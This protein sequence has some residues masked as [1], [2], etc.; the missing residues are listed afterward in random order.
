MIWNKISQMLFEAI[1][2]DE[3]RFGGAQQQHQQKHSKRD[4]IDYLLLRER[5]EKTW[6]RLTPK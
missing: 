4:A 3:N 5:E 6:V 2:D 1:R